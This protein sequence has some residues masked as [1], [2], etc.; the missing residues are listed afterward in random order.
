MMP[1]RFI[2]KTLGIIVLSFSHISDNEK[3]A[4]EDYEHPL[5]SFVTGR[6]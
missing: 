1:L 4:K 5:L 3:E 6:I 2:L